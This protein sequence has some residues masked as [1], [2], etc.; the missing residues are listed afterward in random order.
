MKKYLAVYCG[1]SKGTN[2]LYTQQAKA[3]GQAMVKYNFHLVFGAGNV[4]L[5]GIIADEILRLGGE[6]VGVIPQHLVDMEVAHTGLTELIITDT[7]HERKAIMAERAD[8]FIAMPGGIG[9]LEEII[10]VMTWT[11]LG[12]HQ[13][14]IGFLNTNQFYSQLFNFFEHMMQEKFLKSHPI[15]QLIC[16][17]DVEDLLKGFQSYNSV[18]TPKWL[19]K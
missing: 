7:M 1:S 8:G 11:Q 12:L 13:K 4:G 10:E 9:T 17:A 18:Y 5:M 6:V 15:D 14:P 16:E 3:L 19:D 2:P